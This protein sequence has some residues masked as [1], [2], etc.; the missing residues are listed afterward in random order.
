MRH[1]CSS[2]TEMQTFSVSSQAAHH[3][4]GVV[5]GSKKF[6][7]AWVHVDA[8]SYPLLEP[9]LPFSL[10]SHGPWHVLSPQVSI[11]QPPALS[12]VSTRSI[13]LSL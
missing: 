5:L 13:R 11:R 7:V 6:V 10:P 8:R 9:Q 3:F 2:T 1:I 4:E 12:V